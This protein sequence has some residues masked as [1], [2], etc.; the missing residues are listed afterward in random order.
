MNELL[1]QTTTGQMTLL[2]DGLRAMFERRQENIIAQ[3]K[4]PRW[5][6]DQ[7]SGQPIPNKRLHEMT[8]TEWLA[9]QANAN[10]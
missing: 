9:S 4:L 3:G 10:A 7:V 6:W 1:E 2:G 8:D 5:L